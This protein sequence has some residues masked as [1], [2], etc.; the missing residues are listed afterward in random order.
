MEAN[1][2]LQTD[3]LDLLFAHRNKQYGS[4]DLRKNYKQRMGIALGLT[5]LLLLLAIGIPYLASRWSTIPVPPPATP[6]KEDIPVT[7]TPIPIHKPKPPETSGSS[8]PKAPS[9]RNLPPVVVAA[10][11]IK[12][13][14]QP[15]TQEALKDKESGPAN[16]EGEPG[17]TG[18]ADAQPGNGTGGTG[19]GSGMPGGSNEG[20][21]PG[22]PAPLTF[23]DH[24]PEFPGGTAALM[25][26]LRKH[27]RY[28]IQ[29][30][31]NNIEGK[32]LLQFVVDAKGDITNIQLIRGIGGGCDQE[33][34]RVVHSMPKWK[35]GRLNG[36][37]VSVY[38]TL[39]ISFKL[40]S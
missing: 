37:E 5:F 34:L 30:R 31:E 38:F 36:K 15:P 4:Y 7:M 21:P 18:P 12:P 3:Y 20:L 23:A 33:A 40:G 19:T 24:M 26:F 8:R 17:G 35:P 9:V 27:I 2:I 16:H 32:V 6:A 25:A 22:N 1:Q 28:P 29:A 11:E 39:P 14:D 13:D 10:K